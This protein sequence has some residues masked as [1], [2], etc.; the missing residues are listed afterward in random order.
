MREDE[1]VSLA[2]FA[3]VEPRFRPSE[4]YLRMRYLNAVC[5]CAQYIKRSQGSIPDP[6]AIRINP[7]FRR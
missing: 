3:N 4:R 6:Q 5:T 7:K 1:A 2:V